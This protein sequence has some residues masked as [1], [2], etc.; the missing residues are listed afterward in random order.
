M[1]IFYTFAPLWGNTLPCFLVPKGHLEAL[2]NLE[3]VG[4]HMLCSILTHSAVALFLILFGIDEVRFHP[5]PA[6]QG[7]FTLG[8]PE[9]YFFFQI[10]YRLLGF[11]ERASLGVSELRL[12]ADVSLLFF[13][14]LMTHA[15]GSI[16]NYITF[17][18]LFG[19]NKRRS[20]H[21]DETAPKVVGKRGWLIFNRV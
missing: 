4:K 16:A 3:K 10:F 21:G 15:A 7:L 8:F 20:H 5:L 17:V 1:D 2:L 6:I 12:N 13:F 9:F 19:K 11:F 14:L 18:K